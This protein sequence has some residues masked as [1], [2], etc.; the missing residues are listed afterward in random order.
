MADARCREHRQ[1]STTCQKER[2]TNCMLGMAAPKPAAIHP[3]RFCIH[4]KHATASIRTESISEKQA[5]GAPPYPHS[6]EFCA[7]V[8]PRTSVNCWWLGRTLWK[9]SMTE[10]YAVERWG[11]YLILL[12]IHTI[13]KKIGVGL[14]LQQHSTATA[15][16]RE[17]CKCQSQ[18]WDRVIHLP[19]IQT[20]NQQILKQSLPWKSNLNSKSAEV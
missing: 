13:P 14:R 19:V 10:K 4:C 7:C 20:G 17:Q 8:S 15:T 5:S 9:L 18:H 3:G 2:K 6:T 12:W 1:G 16:T 11:R